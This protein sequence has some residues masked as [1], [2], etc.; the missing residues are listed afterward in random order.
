M[1]TIGVGVC[2]ID[3]GLCGW[4]FFGFDLATSLGSVPVADR[5][6]C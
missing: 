3:F 2:P 4:G 5:L 6:P 1:V